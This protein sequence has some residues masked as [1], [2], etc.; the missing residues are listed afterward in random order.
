MKISLRVGASFIHNVLLHSH[1]HIFMTPWTVD[2]QPPLSMG[3]SSHEYWVGCRFLLQGCSWPRDRIHTSCTSCNSQ[4]DS[5]PCTTWEAHLEMNLFTAWKGLGTLKPSSK[6]LYCL[7]QCSPYNKSL[8]SFSGI[9]FGVKE[10]EACYEGEKRGAL[11]LSSLC[12]W[13][14]YDFRVCISSFLTN[15]FVISKTYD[16]QGE[17]KGKGLVR[18]FGMDTYKLPYLNW[19]TK[20]RL[21]RRLRW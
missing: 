17:G 7:P 14:W 18:E 16:C 15:P 1:V 13:A 3:F 2:H 12:S 19:I 6:P 8:V 4:A 20:K 21:L 5:L 10:I 11:F 9:S